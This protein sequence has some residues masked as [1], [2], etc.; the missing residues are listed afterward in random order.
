MPTPEQVAA[1]TLVLIEAQS[2]AREQI[3]QLTQ[4]AVAA[5]IRAFTGWYDHPA[6]TAFAGRLAK[7][8]RAGQKQTALST[9]AFATRILRYLTGRARPVGAVPVADLRAVPLESVYGRLADQFR[10]LDSPRGHRTPEAWA[11]SHDPAGDKIDPFPRLTREAVLDRVI[12]RGATQVDDNLSLAF[13]HQW[14]ADLE[15]ASTDVIGWRRVIHPELSRSGTCGLC[16]VASDRQY[17]RGDL[18]ALH[19]HC[20]CSVLPIIG[21]GSGEVRFDPG[22]SLN[23]ADLKEIYAQAG[24][25]TAA[26]DL[27]RTRFKV[28]LHSELGPRLTYLGHNTRTAR[29]AL[30]D[31]DIP[32]AE[33]AVRVP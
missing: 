17:A 13:Q 32:P 21:D 6:I 10:Y 14:Q 23:R 31:D 4:A 28:D 26:D 16:L 12:L 1:E 27:Y 9:D 11:G 30:A 3:A 15:Q 20:V 22:A 24:G 29:Q 8:T 2:E 19:S 25:K 33:P 18:M 5:E 7:I